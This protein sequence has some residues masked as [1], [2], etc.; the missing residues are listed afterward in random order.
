MIKKILLISLFA[1]ALLSC[2]S[3]CQTCTQ[4]HTIPSGYYTPPTVGEVREVCNQEEAEMLESYSNS[5]NYWE[6]D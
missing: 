5:Y 1:L 2:E 4:Y 3:N 6:C